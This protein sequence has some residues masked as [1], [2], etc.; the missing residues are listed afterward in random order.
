MFCLNSSIKQRES[1]TLPE[2][3]RWAP[4]D[5]VFSNRQCTALLLPHKRQRLTRAFELKRWRLWR[6]AQTLL[7]ERERTREHVNDI[8]DALMYSLAAIA[9]QIATEL[10]MTRRNDLGFRV[11]SSA[12]F[13]T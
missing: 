10:R 13:T 2:F 5:R 3:S 6:I 4:P 12:R 1:L 8:D 7:Y 11:R 9:T